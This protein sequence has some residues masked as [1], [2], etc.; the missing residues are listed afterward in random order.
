MREEPGR[1]DLG[2]VTNIIGIVTG[3]AGT[4]ALW[5][6]NR[7]LALGSSVVILTLAFLL[8]YRRKTRYFR[9]LKRGIKVILEF[10]HQK[11]YTPDIMVAFTR[12]SAVLAGMLSVNLSVEQLLVISRK[13][14]FNED[15]LVEHREFEIGSEISLNKE[16][17]SGK[18]VLI[19]FIAVETGTTLKDGLEFLRKQG[20]SEKME[21][22]ALYITPGART[23][24]PDVFAVYETSRDITKG[25]PWIFGEYKR[26]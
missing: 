1:T 10:L 24:F 23:A 5:S 19:V 3:I 18:K 12:T 26:V 4:I 21:V 15:G 2:E 16:E 6:T 25:L 13:T 7:D 9:E 11:K 8:A 22:V 17:F 14:K 20:L